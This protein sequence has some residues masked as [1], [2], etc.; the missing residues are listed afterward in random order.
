MFR[1]TAP[2][3][4]TFVLA[5]LSQSGCMFADIRVPYDDNVDETVLGAKVGRSSLHAVLWLVSW[6]DAST[7]A[8]ADAGDIQ[9][10]RHLDAEYKIIL[11]GLY[12]RRTLIAYGD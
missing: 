7:A 1:R 8:A 11:W 12:A 5:A 9:V 6:G 2:L 3:L 10:I 4:L